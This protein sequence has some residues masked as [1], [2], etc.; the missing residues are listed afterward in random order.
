MDY[1]YSFVSNFKYYYKSMNSANLSG[2]IDVIVVEQ[3]DGTFLCTPFHV[4]FGKFAVFNFDEKYVDIQVN[5]K[6]VDGIK[7]KL[8]DNGVAFFVEEVDDE[9][10]LP[11]HLATSPLP[12]K[13]TPFDVKD[14]V[15]CTVNEER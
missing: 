15:A 12:T 7:M 14:S 11:D 8:A 1:F 9:E 6:T 3:P 2:A 10:D 5:Q 13:T 4:R